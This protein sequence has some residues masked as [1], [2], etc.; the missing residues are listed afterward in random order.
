[1]IGPKENWK[2]SISTLKA[3]IKFAIGTTKKLTHNIEGEVRR[4]APKV[5]NSAVF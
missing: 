3:V 5:I 1:M 2:L 4:L